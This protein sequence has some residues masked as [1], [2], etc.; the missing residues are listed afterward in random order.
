MP[1]TFRTRSRPER[2]IACF[3]G[4]LLAETRAASRPIRVALVS[5]ETG[6][7]LTYTQLNGSRE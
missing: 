1:R 5:V 2:F 3:A 4:D 6:E 7:R